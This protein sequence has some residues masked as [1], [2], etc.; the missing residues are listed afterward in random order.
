M[1]TITFLVPKTSKSFP[2]DTYSLKVEN[3]VGIA[4]AIP[5]FAIK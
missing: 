5:D 4:T 3:K 2:A 1:D